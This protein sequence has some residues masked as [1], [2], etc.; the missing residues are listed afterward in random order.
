MTAG[1]QNLDFIYIKDCVNAI[2][3]IVENKEN[4][5]DKFEEFQIGTGKTMFLKDFIEI[6]KS[7]LNSKSVINYGAVEY[8]K[9]E[10]MFSQANISRIKGWQ[11]Q[12]NVSDIDFSKFVL[13]Q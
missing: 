1:G 3:H 2:A 11:P 5:P 8:R 12:Y 7:R 6:I 9:N 13:K 4:F 10:Q